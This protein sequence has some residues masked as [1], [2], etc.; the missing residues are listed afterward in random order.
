MRSSFPAFLISHLT[1]AQNFV[2]KPGQAAVD[3][4][5]RERERVP[6][7]GAVETKAFVE[8]NL[9]HRDVTVRAL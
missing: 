2:D 1:N 4:K 9:L 7:P 6:Q 8:A 3:E 5:E